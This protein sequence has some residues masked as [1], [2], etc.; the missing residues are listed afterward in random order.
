MRNEPSPAVA[1]HSCRPSRLPVRQARA[2][3]TLS[4]HLNWSQPN[5][6]FKLSDRAQRARLY[7]I[8]LREGTPGDV[9]TYI[10]V[11]LLID[12]WD[13]LVLPELFVPPGPTSST[14]LS[15]GWPRW[16]VFYG[17]LRGWA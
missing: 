3:I 11:A 13:N 1:P 9:L 2:T 6:Q 16:L 8:V 15:R 12:L 10:D 14:P 17:G 4:L 5:R 7:E